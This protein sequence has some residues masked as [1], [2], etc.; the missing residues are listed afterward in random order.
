MPCLVGILALAFPRLAII[1][2]WLLGEYLEQAYASTLWPVLGFFFMP[3]TTLGYAYA[4]HTGGGSINGSA[5]G[6]AVFIIALLMDL[7]IL[8]GGAA[9]RKGK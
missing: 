4:W 2:V 1:L 3:V 8:G 7:G 6:M 5:W 9:S